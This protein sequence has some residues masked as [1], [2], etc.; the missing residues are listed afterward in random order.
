LR[1]GGPENGGW[2]DAIVIRLGMPFRNG[3]NWQKV[4]FKQGKI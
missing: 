3:L 1:N 2:V 4:G